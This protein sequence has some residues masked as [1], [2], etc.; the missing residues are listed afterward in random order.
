MDVD[1]PAHVNG[2]VVPFTYL[3]VCFNDVDGSA[4]ADGSVDPFTNFGACAC[5]ADIHSV[6]FASFIGSDDFTGSDA[7]VI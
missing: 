6:S 1:G 7:S 4:D 5:D 3:N 2:S